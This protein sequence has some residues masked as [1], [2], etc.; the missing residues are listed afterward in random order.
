VR[1]K[2]LLLL[3]IVLMLLILGG[4]QRQNGIT[5]R[6]MSMNPRRVGRGQHGYERRFFRARS[7]IWFAWR[8][9]P[10]ERSRSA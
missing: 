5:I 4:A 2:P 3:M 6:S 1:G 7:S 10:N 9:L 8:A